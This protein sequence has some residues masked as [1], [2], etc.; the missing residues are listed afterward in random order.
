MYISIKWNFILITQR[1]KIQQILSGYGMLWASHNEIVNNGKGNSCDMLRKV[2]IYDDILFCCCC[3]FLLLLF[4]VQVF[5]EKIP[6]NNLCWKNT[7][8]NGFCSCYTILLILICEKDKLDLAEKFIVKIPPRHDIIDNNWLKDYLSIR[9]NSSKIRTIV[10]L[11]IIDKYDPSPTLGVECEAWY[12]A[13]PFVHWSMSS[14]GSKKS[15]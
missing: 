14:V 15:T 9:F 4:F 6:L 11:D 13:N 7:S 2:I 8:G 5:G 12:F 10:V 3:C 1:V